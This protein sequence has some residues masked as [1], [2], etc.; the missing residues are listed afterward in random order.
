MERQPFLLFCFLFSLL[1]SA[2]HCKKDRFDLPPETTIGANTFGC[3]NDGAGYRP[4]TPGTPLNVSYTTTGSK[5][6]IYRLKLTDG[7]YLYAHSKI[8]IG[9]Y[10]PGT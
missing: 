8:W 5:E 1:L 6:W 4:L 7:S 9:T 10:N 3:K 2:A